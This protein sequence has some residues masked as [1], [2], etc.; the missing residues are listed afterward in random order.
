MF[1]ILSLLYPIYPLLR[2]LSPLKSTIILLRHGQSTSNI[3]GVISSCRS[4]ENTSR[5]PLTE[6]GRV[7]ASDAGRSLRSLIEGEDRAREGRGQGGL[8]EVKF[9]S[10][11]FRRAVETAEIARRALEGEMG[12]TG[13]PS[14]PSVN[15][16]VLKVTEFRERYFGRLDGLPLSTYAY[17]WPVDMVTTE[18]K[19]FGVES[20]EEVWSRSS[21]ALERLDAEI[22]GKGVCL[23]V[24]GHADT[25]QIMQAGTAGT[26]HLGDF[27]SYRFKN[28]ECRV[29]DGSL[30]E[31]EEMGPPENLTKGQG[32]RHS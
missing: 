12:S 7:Q 24:A 5:H 15:P 1:I 4:L 32:E 20:V 19:G 30:P 3:Q 11:T 22:G 10:S 9:L 14:A 28:G 21:S 27:S 6:V 25:L 29:L 17:V 13:A 26:E 18:N 8:K 16:G 31:R 23:V 2:P